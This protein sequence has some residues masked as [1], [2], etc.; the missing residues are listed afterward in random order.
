MKPVR[1]V[2]IAQDTDNQSTIV[3]DSNA[4]DIDHFITGVQEAASI[5]IWATS[6]TAPALEDTGDPTLSGIPF[7]PSKN[8]TILR[9]CDI[10]PDSR[11]IHRLDEILLNNQKISA[12]QKLMKHP[13][14]HK[15]DCLIYAVV[16]E[17]EVTLIL[18]KDQTKL[19]SG[20]VIVD[21]GSNHAWSNHTDHVCRILF[22]LLDA[23]R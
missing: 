23:H 18:D 2:V 9:I 15:V 20:D 16:L 1:R 11:Y 12:E 10:P 7:L 22:V 8:G 6:K 14:M 19:K 5:N 17:G 3:E 13:L 4:K 21:C